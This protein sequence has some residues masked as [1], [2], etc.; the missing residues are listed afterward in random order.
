MPILGFRKLERIR[1][2]LGAADIELAMEEVAAIEEQLGNLDI[3]A[4]YGTTGGAGK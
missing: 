1:E 2:N 4:L 3:S